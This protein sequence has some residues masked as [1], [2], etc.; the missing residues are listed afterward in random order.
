MFDS[1]TAEEI[2]TTLRGMED[3]KTLITKDAY[4]PNAELYPDGRIPFADIH[5]GY[6]KSHK[7]VNPKHYLSNLRLMITAR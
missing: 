5:L 1:M 3:D 2:L 4:T 7:H 6:L